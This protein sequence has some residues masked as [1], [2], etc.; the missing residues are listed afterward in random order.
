MTPQRNH[1]LGW[2]AGVVGMV[3]LAVGCGSSGD[4]TATTKPVGQTTR[5]DC[6]TDFTPIKAG[7]LSVVTSL[8]GPGFW[9][10]S[11]TDPTKLTGGYEYEIV[12]ALQDKLCLDHVD[13]RNVPFDGLVAGTVTGY[14]VAFSQVTITPDRAKVVRFSAPYFEADQGVL[15]AAGTKVTTIDEARALRWGAQAG[16][17]GLS[18][19]TNRLKPKDDPQVF[20]QF[21][22][23][24]TALQAGQ[25]EAFIMDVP[26]VLAQAASSD[27]TQVVAAQFKTGEQY[28]A[29]LPK[30]STNTAAIDR[31]LDEF[32]SSGK[33][34]EFAKRA[35]GGDPSAVPVIPSP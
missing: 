17:T 4:S 21:A 5:T 35:L 6:P 24:T 12:Q 29:I 13:V 11:D 22:D 1:R 9:V 18:F 23:G 32:R 19:L 14:D 10:G 25:I 2:L 33:L 34:A 7:T 27:G 16:T 3:V 20:Q 28:G 15:V 31:A 26:I 8:P 30:D